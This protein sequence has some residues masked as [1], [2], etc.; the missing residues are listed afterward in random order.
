MAVIMFARTNTVPVTLQHKELKTHNRVIRDF[1][2][3]DQTSNYFC[4]LTK[5]CVRE[6]PLPEDRR[7]VQLSC[8]LR[9]IKTIMIS[10]N[11]VCHDNAVA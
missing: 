10:P 8:I 5:T 6:D 1:R 11:L 4:P 9:C 3:V 2:T 7:S